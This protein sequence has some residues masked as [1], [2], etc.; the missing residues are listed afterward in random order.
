MNPIEYLWDELAHPVKKRQPTRKF[1]RQRVLLEEWNG[2]ARDELMSKYHY[3][4]I[5][6]K[7]PPN[8]NTLMRKTTLP[9]SQHNKTKIFWCH[10]VDTL[11]QSMY[12]KSVAV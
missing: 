5:P 6:E 10:D 9:T 12:S 8:H 2:I 1:H 3:D 7:L 11:I 4:R